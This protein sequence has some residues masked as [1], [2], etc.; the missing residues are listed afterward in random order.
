MS[1]T[2]YEK[3]A[4]LYDVYVQLD[5]DLQLFLSEAAQ[6]SGE[7]LELMSGTGRLS[8][9]LIESGVSLT[10]VD[11]SRP[12]L[13]VLRQKI[14][15]KGLS[16]ALVEMDVCKLNL[17]KKYELVLLPFHSFAE[18]QTESDQRR[19]LRKIYEHLSDGGRFICALHNPSVRMKTVNGRKKLIGKYQLDEAGGDLVVWSIENYDVKTKLVTA[20]QCYEKYDPDGKPLEKIFVD[21]QFRL[22]DKSTFTDMIETEGFEVD[23]LYG[24]YLKNEYREEVSPVMIWCLRKSTV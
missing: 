2:D 17:G 7:V 19:A 4:H 10:C 18:I 12:M 24:D 8:L 11:S 20:H 9:P 22:I 23:A 13:D 3:I 21:I 5:F 15:A 6:V 16:A 1:G 14:E